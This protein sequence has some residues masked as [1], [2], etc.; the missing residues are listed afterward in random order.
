MSRL[1]L[2]LVLSLMAVIAASGCTVPSGSTGQGVVIEEFSTGGL[3]DLYPGEAV[4]FFLKFRN[5]GTVTA[6]G[7]FAEL[8]GLD[9]DWAASSSGIDGNR[10]V[11]GEILPRETRCQYTS[12]DHSTL[13]PPDPVYGT[14]GETSICTWMY[15]T[16]DIPQGMNPTYKLTARLFYDYHTSLVKS[17]TILP[18]SEL[19]K[20][21]QQGRSIPSG[22]V[23]STNSPI[24]ITTEARD[25]IRFWDNGG[26]SF[27][28]A[29]TVSN[30]GG[31]MV[32]TKGRCRK[33]SSGGH[34]WNTL[35]LKIESMG[36][37]LDLSQECSH[38]RSGADIGVWPNRDNTIVCNIEVS[39]V[40]G[41]TSFDERLL[42]ITAEYSYFTD[43]GIS[44]TVL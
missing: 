23:S 3:T 25:P 33:A 8:L 41:I 17:F 26:V 42:E 29:I 15:R 7:V 14:Q 10:I 6:S 16:P 4:T 28:L 31:G 21:N 32:C 11:G 30:T 2:S 13:Q 44:I 24:T 36:D 40:S 43:S 5:Q 20:Y 9:E 1:F 18:T 38:F 27:P 39:D 12:S 22:T 34:E 19:Q 35:K 37:G